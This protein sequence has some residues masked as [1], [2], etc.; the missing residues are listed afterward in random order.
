MKKSTSRSSNNLQSQRLHRLLE[1]NPEL[2]NN[3]ADA[4]LCN[5]IAFSLQA[6]RHFSRITQKDLAEKVGVKQSNISRWEQPG[7]QGYK[8]KMLNKIVRALGGRLNISISPV[9]NS[10]YI[11]TTFDTAEEIRPISN[12]GF[13]QSIG[14]WRE[15]PDL[16]PQSRGD[17]L[18]AHN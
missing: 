1:N 16:S 13:A 4:K 14:L 17:A 18:Y 3:I 9:I 8:V 10:H 2:R 12:M 7:Y 5:D 11:S 15:Y 6:L